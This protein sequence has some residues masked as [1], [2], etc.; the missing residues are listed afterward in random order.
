MKCNGNEDLISQCQRTI[1]LMGDCKARSK[2]FRCFGQRLTHGDTPY[3]GRLELYH[4]GHWGTVCDDGFGDD[5][6]SVEWTFS[7]EF[8]DRSDDTN[9]ILD[10]IVC[11]GRETSI[12]NCRHTSWNTH[13]CDT[14]HRE[15]VGIQCSP[16]EMALALEGGTKSNEGIAQIIHVVVVSK[17]TYNTSSDDIYHEMFNCTGNETKLVLCP[18]YTV[19]CPRESKAAIVC[20]PDIWWNCCNNDNTTHV[21]LSENQ[22]LSVLEFMPS[23]ECNGETCTCFVHHSETTF[24]EI[25]KAETLEV[26]YAVNEVTVSFTDLFAGLRSYLICRVAGG[27]PKPDAKWFCDDELQTFL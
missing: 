23:R 6:A 16:D 19:R 5:Q 27:N 9:Y 22:I 12:L 26:Y 3:N 18:R 7:Y 15:D 17:H 21:V 4:D 25:Q 8:K 14:K 11:T 20:V 24:P 2:A 13:N 10:D 1:H